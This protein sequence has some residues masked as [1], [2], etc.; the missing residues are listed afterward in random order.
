VEVG[1]DALVSFLRS[2]YFV[3][4]RQVSDGDRDLLIELAGQ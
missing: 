4:L 2:C 3:S 1:H